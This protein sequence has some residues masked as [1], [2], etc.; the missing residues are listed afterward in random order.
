MANVKRIEIEAIVPFTWLSGFDNEG[1]N[2]D[3]AAFFARCL[4]SPTTGLK[5]GYA[6]LSYRPNK[7]GG[8]TAM[9]NLRIWGREAIASAAVVRMIDLLN[10]VGEVIVATEHDIE[11]RSSGKYDHLAEEYV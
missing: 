7:H 9:Y 10:E 6:Q 3:E 5:Y 4:M 11:D 1:L 2:D 8:K